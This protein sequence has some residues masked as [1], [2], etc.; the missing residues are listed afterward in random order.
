[1]PPN[2]AAALQLRAPL[3][4]NTTNSLSS[5]SAGINSLLVQSFL[6]QFYCIFIVHAWTPLTAEF[7]RSIDYAVY[8]Y[9]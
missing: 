6:L 7:E 2:N 5:G 1:M 9:I 3:Q 8:L 4:Q